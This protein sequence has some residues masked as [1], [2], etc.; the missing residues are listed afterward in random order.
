MRKVL[1]IVGARPNF[2][3]VA[4]I[5]RA[6]AETGKLAQTLV[7]TGQHYDV[8]MSDVFFKEL[9]LPTPEV[10]LGIGGGTQTEQTAKV[11]LALEKVFLEQRPDLVSVVGDVNGTLAAALVA[12]KLQLPVAH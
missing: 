7:H 4:P 2:M 11:M 12:A 10:H 1:H 8:K 9:G 6:I 3:K 5:H